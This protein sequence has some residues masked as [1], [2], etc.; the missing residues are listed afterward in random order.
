MAPTGFT[1]AGIS[2][3]A[4]SLGWTDNASTE[5]GYRV[6][7]IPGPQGQSSF[8]TIANLGVD[9]TSFTDT[10][11]ASDS[12]YDYRVAAVNDSGDSGFATTSGTTDAPPSYT[13]YGANSDTSVA[14]TV[15]GTSANT[16]ADD[17]SFQSITERDS[18]GKPAKRHTY[19]EHRW[20]FNISAGAMVTLYANAWSSGSS[21]GDTFNFEFSV[22]NGSSFS[23]LFNVSATTSGNL[24][25]AAIP[26][27]PS[28]SV[29][30]R[31]V[32]TDRTS[33]HREKNTINV[34]HLY[35]QVGNPSNDPPDGDPTAL[36]ASAV[37]S[38][39]IN[40]SWSNGS[41]NESGFT[42]ERSAN[43]STGWSEIADLPAASTSYSDTG[44]TALTTYYYR[45]SAYTQP[46]MISAYASFNATTPEAPP[47]PDIILEASGRKVKGKHHVDL[48]WDSSTSVN[49]YRDNNLVGTSDG[50]SY[51][52]NI[53]TKGGAT[54]DHK[55]CEAG[56]TSACSNTTTTVF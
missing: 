36:S 40:L 25:M 43:G 7:R 42:V 5:T 32:D 17:G 39:Q 34:D 11:L 50:N 54:Y 18:G 33:G 1:A 49:I 31:V 38:S 4:I 47:P 10:G 29:I 8:T 55:V 45:V 22:N 23:P 37:S 26:G 56:N 48:T 51:D 44:L 46:Q 2:E 41:T 27:A 14:G 3:S 52:D 13:N 35:I 28:G 16:L 15:S 19:L 53:G 12:T 20:N 24:Q 21:D 30:I 9:A 6:E